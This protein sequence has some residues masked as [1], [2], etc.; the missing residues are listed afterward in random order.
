MRFQERSKDLS[1]TQLP[2]SVGNESMLFLPKLTCDGRREI[3]M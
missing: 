3:R 2:T 1:L